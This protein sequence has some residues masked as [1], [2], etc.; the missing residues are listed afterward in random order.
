MPNFEYRQPGDFP[1]AKAKALKDKATRSIEDFTVC[2]VLDQALAGSGTLVDIDGR[3]G[4]LTAFH[5][6]AELKRRPEASL[7]LIIA[8]YPHRFILAR[9]CLEFIELGRPKSRKTDGPDLSFIQITGP[10]QLSRLRTMKS[11]YRTDLDP[12][13]DFGDIPIELVHWFLVGAPAILAKQMTSS[14]ADGAMT[15]RFL[16]AEPRF[17]GLRKHGDIARFD[18][19]S[20][21][22]PF[23]TDY[24]GYSGGGV[25]V[26][27]FVKPH[28]SAGDETID[29]DK[30]RLA[31]VIFYQS[32]V[33]KGRRI[34]YANGPAL[35]KRINTTL[36]T[37]G[38]RA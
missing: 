22:P 19:D 4:I 12:F 20:T 23:A 9:E 32:K 30:C 27:V 11:F 25:W 38:G 26:S 14:T 29:I 28:P 37:K 31:G 15:T 2:F 6:A 7:S 8:K 10:E 18:I 36:G 3:F 33:R 16:I 21:N 24:K 17:L 34:I 5:V 13:A 35:L 1:E